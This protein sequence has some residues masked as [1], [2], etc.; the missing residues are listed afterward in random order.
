MDIVQMAGQCDLALKSLVWGL[1]LIT[2]NLNKKKF[3]WVFSP[4]RVS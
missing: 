4:M 3:Y 2:T 1:F